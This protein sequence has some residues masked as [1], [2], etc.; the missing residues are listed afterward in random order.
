MK[1]NVALN[2][3]TLYIANS[4]ITVATSAKSNLQI[5]YHTPT[6]SLEISA[7]FNIFHFS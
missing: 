6:L 7:I 4:D 1:Q 2:F 5:L 3:P